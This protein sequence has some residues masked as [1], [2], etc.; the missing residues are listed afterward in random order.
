VAAD[1][2]YARQL[3]HDYFGVD[4]TLVWDVVERELPILRTRL[5]KLSGHLDDQA[6]SRG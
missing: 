4:L 2:R 1:R 3:I 5:E 6:D